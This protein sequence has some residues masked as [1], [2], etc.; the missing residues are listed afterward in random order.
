MTTDVCVCVGPIP[1]RKANIASGQ[2]LVQ[3]HKA[4]YIGPRSVSYVCCQDQ[5]RIKA[6]V[7]A[8]DGE[9]EQS[10][11]AMPGVNGISHYARIRARPRSYLNVMV[12]RFGVGLGRIRE[13]GR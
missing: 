11:C 8:E 9:Y 3:E 5:I 7:F 13:G 10:A 12:V 4:R 2:F 6:H 1:E